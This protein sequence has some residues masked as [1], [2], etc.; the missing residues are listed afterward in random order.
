[1]LQ[2]SAVLESY[3]IDDVATEGLG[4]ALKNIGSKISGAIKSAIKWIADKIAE[5]KKMV[6]DKAKAFAGPDRIHSM[7]LKSLPGLVNDA[8]AMVIKAFKMVSTGKSEDSKIPDKFTSIK[9]DFTAKTDKIDDTLQKISEAF[10]TG[11]TALLS[12]NTANK[13]I[14]ALE[15]YKS[16]L[17]EVEKEVSANFGGPMA[18][19]L[20]AMAA[21]M[22]SKTSAATNIIGK[23]IK[24]T[25]TKGKS[26]PAAAEA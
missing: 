7:E 3:M 6:V 19:D 18:S 20:G 5:F 24:A 22:I 26:E 25:A 14:H 13:L 17:E 9:E 11:E 15:K 2:V 4:S 21:K 16:Q 12:A 10:E 1:M 23:M 8:N